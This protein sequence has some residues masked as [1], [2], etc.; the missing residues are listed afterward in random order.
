MDVLTGVRMGELE[1]DASEKM[2]QVGGQSAAR[3]LVRHHQL[4]YPQDLRVALGKTRNDART[5]AI[6]AEEADGIIRGFYAEAGEG[7]SDDAELLGFTV[8]GQ[9][10]R[11]RDQVVTFCFT[12]SAGRTGKGFV[13]YQ[14]LPQ[15]VAAGDR[16]VQIAEAR[17]NG[18]PWGSFVS[19]PAAA[20]PVEDSGEVAELRGEVDELKATVRS[21]LDELGAP[22]SDDDA[23][24]DDA[25]DDAA[26]ATEDDDVSQAATATNDAPAPAPEPFEGYEGTLAQNIVAKLKE[27][28]D[29]ELAKAVIAYEKRPD[30]GQN[31]STVVSAAEHVLDRQSAGQ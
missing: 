10:D 7:L 13:P 12:T 25:G 31:R 3:H 27:S 20:A 23:E 6:N 26:A 28:G 16:A 17:K 14:E 18:E 29:A 22:G 21:L 15:S 9:D 24:G 4:L 19:A 11:P 1:T 8:R 5:D 30:M 2:G